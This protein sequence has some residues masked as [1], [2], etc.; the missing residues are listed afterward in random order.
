MEAVKALAYFEEGEAVN[1]DRETRRYLA[2]QAAA[3]DRTVSTMGKT[4]ESLS[5]PSPC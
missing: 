5:A 1:V 2:Q 4:A 3:W